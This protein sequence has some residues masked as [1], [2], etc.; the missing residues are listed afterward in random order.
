MTSTWVTKHL[1]TKLKR[2]RYWWMVP[3]PK[4]PCNG[5]ATQ[6]ELLALHKRFLHF[7]DSELGGN[8]ADYSQLADYLER[9]PPVRLRRENIY[10][11][12]KRSSVTERL[13]ERAAPLSFA[14]FLALVYPRGTPRA[15]SQLMTWAQESTARDALQQL[16]RAETLPTVE[17][18][19]VLLPM[20]GTTDI[21]S[22]CAHGICAEKDVTS[23]LEAD[24]PELL[25]LWQGGEVFELKPVHLLGLGTFLRKGKK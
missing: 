12:T 9:T 23:W 13:N 21:R 11:P 14:E 1:A 15:L 25:P 7:Q 22:L 19:G 4:R 6:E 5:F 20:L 24:R 17:L 18:L 2:D 3:R 8:I 16:F 10:Y